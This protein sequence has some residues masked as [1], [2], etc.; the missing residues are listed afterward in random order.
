[1]AFGPSFPDIN[2]ALSWYAAASEKAKPAL[3]ERAEAGRTFKELA[4]EW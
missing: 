1:M 2:E 4:D 3:K